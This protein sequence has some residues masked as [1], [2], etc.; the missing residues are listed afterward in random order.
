MFDES[1]GEGHTELL[2]RILSLSTWYRTFPPAA[3]TFS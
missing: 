3:L 1:A 2:I